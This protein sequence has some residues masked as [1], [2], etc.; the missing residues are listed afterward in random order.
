L[1]AKPGHG[2]EDS[3]FGR[4]SVR[5][6]KP[7]AAGA[8]TEVRPDEREFLVWLRS[9]EKRAILPLK[10]AILVTAVLFWI[11]AR[12]GDTLPPVDLF[13][14]FVTYFMFN[15]G[16]SYFLWVSRV[17]LSQVRPLCF[18]SYAM[19]VAFVT[20][21]VFIDSQNNSQFAAAAGVP[22]GPGSDF[23]VF[24][25]LLILR[26]F[27]LFPSPRQNV[28]ANGIVGC[29][30]VVSLI[31]LQDATQ[32]SFATPANLIRVVFILLV[33]LMSW[34]IVE[35]L[36]RQKAEIMRAQENLIRS[37]NMALV[38]QLAAGVAHEIN[39]PIG[40]IS[41]YAEYLKRSAAEG[42]E[43]AEDFE[44]IHREAQ[45]CKE[46]VAELLDYARPA[47]R[48]RA[49][50]DLRVLL[51]DVADFVFRHTAGG[52]V[53]VHREYGEP[54]PL[55]LIDANQMKQALLNVLMNARQ[56]MSGR[57]GEIGLS[58]QYDPD[59]QGIMLR[60]ADNGPGIPP[61]DL[62]RVFDPFFTSRSEGT[63]LGLS[64]TKR[65]VEN[66]GGT[67]T[68]DSVQGRGTTVSFFVPAEPPLKG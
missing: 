53:R 1:S 59:R 23:Y 27:A 32:P 62:K 36:N 30:F 39:N 56:A 31:I 13:A 55:V 49:L 29:I 68:M 20:A 14:L 22:Y 47:A 33:I 7:G 34:F 28:I 51:D 5:L 4:K 26:S 54:L 35:I 42:D 16:E 58:L 50:S 37:E 57:G 8:P 3:W 43:R 67:V 17:E 48:S 24:Y 60:V 15:L 9:V 11:L 18:A 25:F 6:P 21:L 45:R 41:V 2:G 38:G 10:W 46:I 64:I 12:P 19:D 52:D 40:I 63:G 66:H 44:A 65:V 61:E